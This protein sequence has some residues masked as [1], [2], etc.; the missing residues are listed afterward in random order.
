MPSPA[1]GFTLIELLVVV[2]VIAIL[3]AIAVPNFLEAMTRAK[4]T[5]TKSDLRTLATAL[6]SY[7]IDK[8]RYPPD[9]NY[10]VVT[11]V[12]RLRHLTTPIAYISSV[13][14]DPFADK[15]EIRRHAQ[16]NSLNAYAAGGQVN[17]EFLYPLTYDYA[18][19]RTPTGGFEPDSQ[20]GRVTGSPGA[21]IW[22]MRGIGPDRWPAWLGQDATPY[23]PTNGTVSP[24][25]IFWSG[26]GVGPD[27][28]RDLP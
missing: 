21:V 3:A 23:D 19:R 27:V 22:A 15:G 20:W 13:P 6:E 18:N 26:P 16:E 8:N 17:G 7:R 2:A 5:R 24:G 12:E 28:P 4:V 14:G 10:G 25:S 9:V 11:Y 1:R